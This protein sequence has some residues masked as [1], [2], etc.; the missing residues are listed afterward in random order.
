[1]TQQS[2]IEELKCYRAKSGTEYPEEIKMA[3]VA[4]EEIQHYRAIGTVEECRDARERC[5]NADLGI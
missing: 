1:M 4:L 2:A 3:I 5:R